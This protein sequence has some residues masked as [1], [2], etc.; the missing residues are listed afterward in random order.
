MEYCSYFLKIAISIQIYLKI[1][2]LFCSI[3]DYCLDNPQLKLF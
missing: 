3:D 2:V 1:F